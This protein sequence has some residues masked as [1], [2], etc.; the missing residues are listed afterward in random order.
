MPLRQLTCLVCRRS[1][2]GHIV[3]VAE[4]SVRMPKT[5]RALRDL[6]VESDRHEAGTADDD[7][8]REATCDLRSDRLPQGE[9]L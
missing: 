2:L 4:P 3:I 1:R 8:S 5:V 7:V 9:W 6:G